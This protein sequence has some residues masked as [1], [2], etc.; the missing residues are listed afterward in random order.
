MNRVTARCARMSRSSSMF[1]R[2]RKRP[3]ILATS[4]GPSS[5]AA[6]AKPCANFTTRFIAGKRPP[7]NHARRHANRPDASRPSRNFSPAKVTRPA[8]WTAACRDFSTAPATASDWKSTKRRASA[9]LR[10]AHLKAGQ[11]VTVEPGLILSGNWRRALGR[12]RARHRQGAPRNLTQ[13][14]KVLEV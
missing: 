10:R 14:E 1:S 9:R 3:A 11:V 13:F 6:P 8:R 5:K 12:C 4:P 7:F 2:A